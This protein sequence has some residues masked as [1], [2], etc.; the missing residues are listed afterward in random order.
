[1]NEIFAYRLKNARIIAGL[2]MEALADLVGVTKQMI[3]KY[4]NGKS[5]PDSTHLIKLSGALNQKVDYFF[6]PAE[7]ELPEVS[8]RKKYALKG[9]R[10]KT[11]KGLIH[12]QTENY[13]SIE[14]FLSIDSEFENP[15]SAIEINAFSDIEKAAE[16]LREK[17]NLGN[18]PISN[19]ISLLESKKIKV[20]EIEEENKFD[21]LSVLIDNKYPV[22][23]INKS[24]P[25]E[26]KRFTLLHELG[27]L[28]LNINE[29]FSDKDEEM[30]CNRFA[31]ALL[32]PEEAVYE[33]FGTDRKNISFPELKN[34]QELYGISIRAIMYRLK[35]LVVISA[36]MHKGFSIRLNSDSLL[37]NEVDEVRFT[38]QENT[39]RYN[40][41]VYQALSKEL[42]SLSKASSLLGV[43]VNK[44]KE[45]FALI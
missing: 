6:R 10:L 12:I 25:V 34:I 11:L 9:K 30:F 18:D 37:K 40:R 13:L 27:H 35:D 45:E 22:I 16:Q 24:F 39:G 20:I 29:R 17:W 28:L 32:L 43:A 36:G 44:V 41:L 26:R 3:S 19:V 21:G 5:V 2:S 8:F 14:S 31:G 33:N 1:M 4:E 42:I 15:I 38:E 7:V 23:V